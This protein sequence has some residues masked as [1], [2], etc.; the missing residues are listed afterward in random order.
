[1]HANPVPERQLDCLQ[2]LLGELC[3]RGH[4][5]ALVSLPFAGTLDVGSR[6]AAAAVLSLADEASKFLRRR[7]DNAELSARPQ[8]YQV[9]PLTPCTFVFSHSTP[10]GCT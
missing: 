6:G 8:P 4:I 3:A 1:M 5:A 7:A 9:A 10:E 2:P